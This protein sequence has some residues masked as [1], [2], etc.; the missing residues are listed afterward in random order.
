MSLSNR[1][2]CESG[3]FS[4]CLNPH[5]FFQLEVLRFYFPSLEP[6]V[7]QSNL[8]CSPV[9]P[10]S[11]SA[12]Q[13]GIT[14]SASCHL[15]HPSP[16]ATALLGSPLCLSCP[17]P[18]LLLVWVNVYSLTPWL[19]D[20]HTIGFSGRCGYFLFLNWLLSFFWLCKEVYLSLIH[21]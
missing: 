3:G 11:L 9:A 1:L 5:R 6:Q 16:P 8:S 4:C 20:F 7:E 10:P 19:S 2:S 21:I 14:Q 15:T 12:C 18:P 13:C 17:S